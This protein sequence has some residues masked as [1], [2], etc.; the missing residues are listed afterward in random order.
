MWA[1]GDYPAVARAF[2]PGFGPRLVEACGIGPGTRVLDVAA[3][4]GNVAIPAARAGASV[5]AADL[6]PELLDAGRA[7]AG[8]AAIEWVEADAEALPFPDASFDAVVSAVG[9]M[10]APDHGRVAAELVRVTRPGGTIGLIN[11]TP[12]GFI[13]RM[14]KTMAPYAPPPPAGAQPPPRWGDEGYV[15]GLLGDAVEWTALERE[16][17][18][19]NG[20]AD[21]AAYRDFF[22]ANYGPTIAV[23]AH[24]GDDAERRETLDRD[25]E[26]LFAQQLRAGFGWEYLLAVGRVTRP[27][28]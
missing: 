3:G 6:T 18:A 4:A 27:R 14:F 9:T 25:L 24:V 22:K 15:R 20:L 13:G 17:V 26:A 11:W 7:E 1:L 23:Y 8:D 2:I 10:F 12:E 16:A 5:V 21:A 28:A 19:V